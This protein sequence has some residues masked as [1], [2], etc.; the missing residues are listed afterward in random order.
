M[1]RR[2]FLLAGLVTAVALSAAAP[3]FA[4]T[5]APMRPY[6]RVTR[7]QEYVFVMLG[8]PW[9]GPSSQPWDGYP[10]SGLYRNDGSRD[11]L[12]TVDWYAYDVDVASDGIHLV[13]HGGPATDI[14]GDAIGFYVNG[15]LLESYQIGDV[16]TDERRIN[17]SVSFLHWK[18]DGRFYEAR[19]EYMLRTVDG[20]L[21]LFDVNTGAIV[22]QSSPGVLRP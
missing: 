21:I 17:R 11:P 16:V 19:M 18:L 3:A 14:Y 10:Q 9:P 7:S 15:E 8:G 2:R 13:R 5:P 1:H 12:W 22:S 6:K 4:D 20:N